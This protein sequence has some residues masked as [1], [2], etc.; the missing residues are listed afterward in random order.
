MPR[1]RKPADWHPEDIKAALRKRGHTL[2]G[3]SVANGYGVS[4]VGVVLRRPAA[5]VQALIASCL[6]VTPQTIWPSRYNPDG[7]PR[8]R[9]QRRPDRAPAH[10]QKCEAR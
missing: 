7:S 9:N 4:T 10:R 1:R 8:R 6:D 2:S 5:G 3:L